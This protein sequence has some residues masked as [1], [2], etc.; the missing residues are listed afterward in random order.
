MVENRNLPVMPSS[1]RFTKQLPRA[2]NEG[3][4]RCIIILMSLLRPSP[5]IQWGLHVQIFA[6]DLCTLR[7]NE[8]K[9]PT[10]ANAKVS[11]E[12]LACSSS[13]SF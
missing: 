2:V 10:F 7:V 1:S 12:D 13:G 5:Q 9:V 3:A 11:S 4:H 6:L 8:D